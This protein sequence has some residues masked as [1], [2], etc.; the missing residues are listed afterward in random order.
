MKHKNF[1]LGRVNAQIQSTIYT[2]NTLDPSKIKPGYLVWDKS[3]NGWF[4]KDESGAVQPLSGGG[5]GSG[6]SVPPDPTFTS[7]TTGTLTATGATTLSGTLGVTGSATF[8]DLTVDGSILV[9][10]AQP[11][12][13]TDGQMYYD[14]T[15][16]LMVYDGT[17]W[18]QFSFVDT[19]QSAANYQRWDSTVAYKQD[20][21]V[22]YN[23]LLYRVRAN[24]GAGQAQA[25][26]ANPFYEVYIGHIPELAKNYISEATPATNPPS[27]GY[28]DKGAYYIATASG[29]YLT[30]DHRELVC[31]KYW[32]VNG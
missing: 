12:T 14:S 17:A 24:M 9:P 18:K 21:I 1:P 11:A 23:G 6:G 16:G 22:L 8:K 4:F 15:T 20:E 5:S 31:I 32:L 25:P 26:D 29:D 7:V 3:Q 10:R 30:S 27:L 2:V 13:A 28:G 19:L